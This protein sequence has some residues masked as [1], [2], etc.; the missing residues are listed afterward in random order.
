V[1]KGVQTADVRKRIGAI[2]GEPGHM[3][4]AEFARYIRAENARWRKLL[5]DGRLNVER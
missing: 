2:G 5:S 4:P 3:T 1:L